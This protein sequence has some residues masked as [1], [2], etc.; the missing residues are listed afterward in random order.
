MERSNQP[1]E[2]ECCRRQGQAAA[3]QA[4]CGAERTVGGVHREIH[5]PQVGV[6][7]RLSNPASK[8]IAAGGD[9]VLNVAPN[10]VSADK[11]EARTGLPGSKSVASEE[12]TARNQGDPELS[13]RTN[14]ESQAGRS[15]QRQEG[16]AEATMGVGSLH[17]SGG[18]G[19]S[20]DR[21]EGGDTRTP[22]QRKPNPQEWRSIGP[23]SLE[24]QTSAFS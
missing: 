12:R 19:A 10:T 9:A 1:P 23:T 5:E 13:R 7:P 4:G 3:P 18:Q 17:S 11:G 21:R 8:P 14:Y 16:Q 15:V 24:H 22:F 6:A 2:P 20:P